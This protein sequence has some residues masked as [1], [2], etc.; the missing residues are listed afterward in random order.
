VNP[1]LIF[2]VSLGLLITGLIGYDVFCLVTHRKT[3]SRAVWELE[4]SLRLLF[5]C[6]FTA[7]VFLL[8]GFLIGH[9]FGLPPECEALLRRP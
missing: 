3:I 4:P 8:A 6:C 2:M 1:L 9:W 5:A 7:V